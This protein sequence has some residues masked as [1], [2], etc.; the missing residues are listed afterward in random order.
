MNEDLFSIDLPA[1]PNNM[2]GGEKIKIDN[3]S[4]VNFKQSNSTIGLITLSIAVACLVFVGFVVY[5]QIDAMI[6]SKS[7]ASS[8]V[9]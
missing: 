6:L 5:K 7:L 9:K 3:R 4:M 2:Q 1:N 8:I